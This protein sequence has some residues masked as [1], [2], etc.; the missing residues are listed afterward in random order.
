MSKSK[1]QLWMFDPDADYSNKKIVIVWVWWVWSVAAYYVSQMWCK[2]ITVIDMDDVEIHNTSSQFYKQSDIRRSK[3]DALSENIAVFND[4]NMETFNEPYKSEHLEWAHIV[5][6]AV[7][8]MDIRKQIVDDSYDMDIPYVIEARMSWEEFMIYAFDPFVDR[9]TWLWFRYPQSEVE[10]V[11]CTMKSISYN[12]W[13]I[14]SLIAKLVKN[15]LRKERIPFFI[16]F[17]IW[18]FNFSSSY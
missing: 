4:V 10:P 1:N 16:S 17:N 14:W 12:T 5:I 8:N 9:D 3:V 13:I 11:V 7:D 15:I 6:A 2:N 18:E